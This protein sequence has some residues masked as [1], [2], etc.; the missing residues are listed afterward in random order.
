MWRKQV[1]VVFSKPCRFHHTGAHS[2]SNKGAETAGNSVVL[3]VYYFY[4]EISLAT[5][6]FIFHGLQVLWSKN[7]AAFSPKLCQTQNIEKIWTVA[8]KSHWLV[9][10]G[11]TS[12]GG[13]NKSVLFLTSECSLYLQSTPSK[14]RQILNTG[15]ILSLTLFFPLPFHRFPISASTACFHN[16]L[17]PQFLACQSSLASE[18]NHVELSLTWAVAISE[19]H[20]HEKSQSGTKMAIFGNMFQLVFW[21]KVTEKCKLRIYGQLVSSKLVM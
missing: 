4:F 12:G 14:Q 19:C 21:H 9:L 6:R 7:W 1:R 15:F 13:L 11:H 16:S 5:Q 20:R 8:G 10:D 17:G 2:C 18:H 3:T